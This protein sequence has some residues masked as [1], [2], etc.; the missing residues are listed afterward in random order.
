MLQDSCQHLPKDN[1]SSVVYDEYYGED[2]RCFVAN[3][4]K[5]HTNVNI[6]ILWQLAHRL[7]LFFV[8]ECRNC[9]FAGQKGILD[10]NKLYFGY[11]LTCNTS[12]LFVNIARK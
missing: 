6:I 5:V 12:L 3:I 1:S 9:V 11:E 4:T 7:Y 8:D 2:S 10:I